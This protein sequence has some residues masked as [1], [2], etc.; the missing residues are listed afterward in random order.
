MTPVKPILL[1]AAVL[2]GSACGDEPGEDPAVC[3]ELA[4]AYRSA[5]DDARRCNPLL[6]APGCTE[7]V[8]DKLVC[9]CPLLVNGANREALDLLVELRRR[10]KGHACTAP[11]CIGVTCFAPKRGRCAVIPEGTVPGRCE[12]EL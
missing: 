12:N 4:I 2:A 3:D 10:W 9:P 6:S 5:L 1:C 11:A 7:P 8:D